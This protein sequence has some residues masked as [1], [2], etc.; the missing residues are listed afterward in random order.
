VGL[1]TVT[2][3][4]QILQYRAGA[5]AWQVLRTLSP[6]VVQRCQALHRHMRWCKT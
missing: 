6:A 5:D 2:T 4:V 3:N 1:V